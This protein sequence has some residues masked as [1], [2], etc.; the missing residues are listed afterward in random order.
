MDGLLHCSHSIEPLSGCSVSIRMEDGHCVSICEGCYLE[1]REQLLKGNRGKPLGPGHCCGLCGREASDEF[2]VRFSVDICTKVCDGCMD[3]QFQSL[4]EPMYDESRFELPDEILPGELYIG[5]KFSA[6]NGTALKELLNI[7]QVMVCC[8]H[9]REYNAQHEV[10]A[11]PEQ[12][13]RYHRLPIHDS[14]NQ[15]L[16]PFLPDA[17]QFIQD[18]H[19]QRGVATLVH[20]NAGVSRSASV[21]I[22]YLMKKKGM[23]F[24]EAYR[25]IKDRRKNI[26]PNSNFKNQLR[27]F[28]VGN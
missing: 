4:S 21:C 12:N 13:L 8:T 14:L 6:V 27:T 16:I 9:L 24:D 3:E 25:F 19:Q 28:S 20:C 5:S 7:H 18:G 10:G 23:T 15:D 17:I 11:K 2:P 22:A 26:F 1:G